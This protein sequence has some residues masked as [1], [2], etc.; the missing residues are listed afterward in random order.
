VTVTWVGHASALIETDGHRVLT[1]PTLTARLAHLRRRVPVPDLAPV[2]TVLI[3]HLHLDHLHLRSL[4][5]LGPVPRLVVPAG[6]GSLV[7]SLGAGEVHEVRAGDEVDL[8]AVTVRAVPAD[9]SSHRGPH[10]RATAEP[11]GYVVDGG[12]VSTYFAGDTD[13]FDGMRDLGPIDLALLPIWGWGPTLGERHLDP[14]RAA[15]ATAWIDPRVVVP[16]HW[17]TYSP[18]RAGRGAPAWLERPLAD[19]RAQLEAGTVD[20]R[21]R[22]LAPGDS[23]VIGPARLGS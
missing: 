16:I 7:R 13:L 15:T 4:R 23:L 6:A 2:D 21:L 17:G 8:G 18:V 5:R 11:V 12:G 3:S 19:F 1:D 20:D 14:A 9:H 10:S 22:V